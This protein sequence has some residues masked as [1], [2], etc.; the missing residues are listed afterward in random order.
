MR[1]FTFSIL[2]V[3]LNCLLTCFA[4]N[5]K[6]SVTLVFIPVYIMCPFSLTAFKIFL[7]ITCFGQFNFDALSYS[8]FH[9]YCGWLLN[10]LLGTI[11]NGFH[12]IW[13]N[14]TIILQFSTLPSSGES[15]FYIRSLYMVPQITNVLSVLKILQS[16]CVSFWN[17]SIVMSSIS[18]VCNSNSSQ[19]LLNSP[20]FYNSDL[21][22]HIKYVFYFRH[23]SFYS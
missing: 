10:K 17:F 14:S 9:G 13:K 7:F 15:N 2:K 16:R 21:P 23:C 8:F 19:R 12:Q 3:L 6:F 20:I 18:P 4:S 5:K 1:A 11:V 22:Y